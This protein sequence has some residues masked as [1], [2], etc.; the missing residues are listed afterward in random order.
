[1]NKLDKKLIYLCVISGPNFGSGTWARNSGNKEY[2]KL[3]MLSKFQCPTTQSKRAKL[4]HKNN[5][6]L[7]VMLNQAYQ[8]VNHFKFTGR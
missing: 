6:N 7:S 8:F 5:P 1:V 2:L 4:L 3:R